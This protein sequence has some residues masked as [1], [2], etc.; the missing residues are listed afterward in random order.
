[1]SATPPSPPGPAGGDSSRPGMPPPP[2]GP[3][4]RPPN[5]PV[6]QPPPPSTGYAVTQGGPGHYDVVDAYRYGWK[7]FTENVGPILGGMAMFFVAAIVVVVVFALLVGGISA[8][9]ST[10]GDRAGMS[11]AFGIGGGLLGV[12]FALLYLALIFL[13]Q[14]AI[15]RAG[16]ALVDGRPLDLGTLLSTDQLGTVVVSSLIVAAISTVGSFLFILPGLVFGFLAQFF[17][18]FVLGHDD[19]PWDAIVSSIRFTVDNVVSV[20]LLYLLGAVVAT[21]G[22][23]LCGVGLLVAFPVIVIA[24]AYTFRV[25]NGEPVTP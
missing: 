8:A 4:N 11:A 15:V 3:P 10:V 22:M 24:Q 17:L 5:Q 23:L 19:G 21:V 16:L 12:V 7:K 6:N 13:V 18:F 9:G 14:A 25:L 1:M 20:L 2:S